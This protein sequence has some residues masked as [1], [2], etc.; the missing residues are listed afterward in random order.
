MAD[1]E[2]P[3]ADPERIFRDLGSLY[4]TLATEVQE[5][6]KRM[7]AL[8]KQG[9]E[10]EERLTGLL[11]ERTQNR[12]DLHGDAHRAH[13]RLAAE[14]R[15]LVTQRMQGAARKIASLRPGAD[16]ET[17]PGQIVAD[18]T[19]HLFL[20]AEPD[21]KAV[22]LLAKKADPK[23]QQLLQA[24]CDRAASLRARIAEIGI[25]HEWD[26][27]ADLL[28]VL[29]EERQETWLSCDPE[30]PVRLVVAP[31]YVV[32][33]QLYARQLVMTAPAPVTT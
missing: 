13:L 11:A 10:L 8:E 23:D 20:P 30:M 2:A 19:R 28:G 9:Q 1:E 27:R 12:P 22:S 33:G 24:V 7:S 17:T 3:L 26:F 21:V 16:L 25:P 32:G 5:S 4:T 15:T 31:A 29:D 6:R 18:L 14:Y